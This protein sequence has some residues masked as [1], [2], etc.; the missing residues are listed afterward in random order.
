MES[1]QYAWCAAADAVAHVFVA[2]LADEVTVDGPDGHH[3]Q[4]VRRLRVGEAITAADGTGAWRRYTIDAVAPGRL[5]LHAAGPA[6]VEPEL[7]PAIGLAIALDQGRDRP[8]R[9]PGDRARR[10]AHRAGARP[11]QRGPLGCRARRR[12]PWP[13]CRRSPGR[14]RPSAAGPRSPTS[15][16]SARSPASWGGPACVIADR[17]GLPASALAD[18]GPAGWTVLVGPEGGF[19]PA[20]L[21]PF[22]DAFPDSRSVPTSCGPRPRRSPWWQRCV[23]ATR[24]DLCDAGH[25]LPLVQFVNACGIRVGA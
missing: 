22:A 24:G 10:R 21:E 18:P 8:R 11:A 15:R 23:V 13:A 5:E 3:L 16:R 2:T 4:R 25:P 17:S 19:D 14:P 20:D 9:R 12:P 7:V 6:R 1:T